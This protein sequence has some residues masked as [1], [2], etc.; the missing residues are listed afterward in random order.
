MRLACESARTESDVLCGQLKSA[1]KKL[2]EYEGEQ[3]A[4]QKKRFKN[5]FKGKKIRVKIRG[6][7]KCQ[8]AHYT[9]TT[10]D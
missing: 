7:D 4:A 9:T 6:G 5:G 2:V 3:E 8:R 1:L 10:G